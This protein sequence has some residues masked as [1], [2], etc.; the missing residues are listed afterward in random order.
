MTRQ[1]ARRTIQLWKR[2]LGLDRWQIVL[3][4]NRPDPGNLGEVE[5]RPP[6]RWARIVLDPKTDRSTII[7]EMLHIIWRMNYGVEEDVVT[8]LADALTLNLHIEE[9]P[10]GTD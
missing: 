3:G 7:H 6:S 2:I 1:E 5:V 9:T 10:N 4:K 8:H